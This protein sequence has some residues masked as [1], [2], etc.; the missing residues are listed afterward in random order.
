MRLGAGLLW[1][2]LL[3][4][5]GV[6]LWALVPAAALL[7]LTVHWWAQRASIGQAICWWD[8]QL[9]AFLV[10]GPLRALLLL[11]PRLKA[12]RFLRLAEMSTLQTYRIGFTKDLA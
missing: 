1:F 6:V 4:V 9:V 8:Q 10:L 2:V 11:D 7:W 12:T 5:R 3:L